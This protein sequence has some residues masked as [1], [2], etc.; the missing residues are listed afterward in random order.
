M[1]GVVVVGV[2]HS[3]TATATKC[4]GNAQR[5]PNGT[6]YIVIKYAYCTVTGPRYAEPLQLQCQQ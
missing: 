3:A 6:I 5:L 4:N 1:I 2:V